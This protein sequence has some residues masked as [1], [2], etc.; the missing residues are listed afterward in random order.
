MN[1]IETENCCTCFVKKGA[2]H[3]ISVLQEKQEGGTIVKM[4]VVL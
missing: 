2:T 1:L 4:T 3:K